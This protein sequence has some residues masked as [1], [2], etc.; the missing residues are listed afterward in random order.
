M[1]VFLGL[2]SN[3]GNRESYLNSAREK[4]TAIDGVK[5]IRASSERV[6]AP[7]GLVDQPEFLNQIVEIETHL[8]PA[9]MLT[10]INIIEN[11][12]GR[13]RNEK[14]GKRTLDI[15][16][17]FW[18]NEIIEQENL[19]IP[20]QDLHNREFIL[21]SMMELEPDLIHPKLGK[22]IKELYNIEVNK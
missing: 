7:Y 20:H 19:T 22:T 21:A 5:M 16:I 8:S 13:I 17:L 3:Q 2:G 12:E 18:G 15:D 1:K 4:L 14:W 10:Q 9:E 6:T 11:Q